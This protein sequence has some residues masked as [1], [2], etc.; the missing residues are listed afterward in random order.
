MMW[1]ALKGNRESDMLRIGLTVAHS[2]QQVK[3]NR[4][5]ARTAYR[6]GE[7]NN[8]D[9]RKKNVLEELRCLNLNEN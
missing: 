9:H 7:Q 5:T 3:H 1:K 4:I 6:I 2:A 8:N